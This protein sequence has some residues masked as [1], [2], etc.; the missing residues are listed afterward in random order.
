MSC[1]KCPVG[2]CG[3]RHVKKKVSFDENAT[4]CLPISED[5]ATG[6]SKSPA[7]RNPNPPATG[8]SKSPATGN[9]KSPA[10]GDSK[11]PATHKDAKPVE[12]AKQVNEE[13]VGFDPANELEM[14]KNQGEM[15]EEIEPLLLESKEIDVPAGPSTNLTDAVEPKDAPTLTPQDVQ[16]QVQEPSVAADSAPGWGEWISSQFNRAK[17]VQPAKHEAPTSAPA[18]KRVPKISYEESQP[19]FKVTIDDIQ[20]ALKPKE[21]KG[22]EPVDSAVLLEPVLVDANDSAPVVGN[23]SPAFSVQNSDLVV[24]SLCEDPDC[25]CMAACPHENCSCALTADSESSFRVPLGGVFLI[26]SSILLFLISAIA[27]Y[28]RRKAV[29]TNK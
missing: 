18:P 19:K 24:E 9:S 12:S 26:I 11:L 22:S 29:K 17:P 2:V 25:D 13:P 23:N 6:N 8:N 27:F 16:P 20:N 28:Q 5:L 7:T 1:K 10:S 21:A 4:F 15:A 14:P 3:Q